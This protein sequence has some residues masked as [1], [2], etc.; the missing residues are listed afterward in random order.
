MIASGEWHHNMSTADY[1]R[2]VGVGMELGSNVRQEESLPEHYEIS[3]LR[4]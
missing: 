2:G 1:A 4:M 3:L